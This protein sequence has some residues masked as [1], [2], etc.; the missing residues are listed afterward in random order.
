MSPTFTGIGHAETST[1]GFVVLPIFLPNVAAMSGDERSGEILRI[2]IEFQVVENCKAG[3]LI[4]RDAMKGYKMDI[5]E[6]AGYISITRPNNAGPIRIPIADGVRYEATQFDPRI[7][8]TEAQTIKPGEEKWVSVE[9]AAQAI[10]EDSP[11]F[12]NPTR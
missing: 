3:F 9:F 2:P 1:L 8:I 4:G 6:S 7:Y 11:L 5:W 12:V 10:A